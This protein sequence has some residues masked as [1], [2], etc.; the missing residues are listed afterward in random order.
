MPFDP[1]KPA[2]H[3]PLSSAE[4]RGQ[5]TGLKALIDSGIPGPKDPPGDPGGPPGPQGPEGPQG[6]PS[7]DGPQGP[8]GNDGAPGP[9][10][11]PGSEGSMGPQ[12][13][14]GVP[15]DPG[16]PPG[17]QGPPGNDGAPGAPGS[18]GE[19][20]SAQLSGA[21]SGTSTNSNA[22]ATLGIGADSTYNPSQIQD[23]INKLDELIT[24]LRRP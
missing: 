5:L 13:P 19:V 1:A 24:A 11:I 14:Q 22:V 15:G 6:A 10:G 4:M 16:G 18:P 17:P 20:T 23:V 21:I 3:A 12:G 8:P 7:N 2:D 9:Q